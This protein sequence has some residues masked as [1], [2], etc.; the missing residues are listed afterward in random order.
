MTAAGKQRAVVLTISVRMTR[1][2]TCDTTADI[3]GEE[4]G[5]SDRS[6]AIVPGNDHSGRFHQEVQQAKVESQNDDGENGH[7]AR[8]RKLLH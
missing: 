1:G 8:H 2:G 3:R 6:R 5:L 7:G 4:P